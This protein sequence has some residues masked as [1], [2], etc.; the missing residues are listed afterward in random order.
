MEL[1]QRLLGGTEKDLSEHSLRIDKTYPRFSE[2]EQ[3][4]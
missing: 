1:N 4:W 2:Y 3:E